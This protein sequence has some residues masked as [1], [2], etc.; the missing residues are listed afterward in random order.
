MKE[1]KITIGGDF[2]RIAVDA[3]EEWRKCGIISEKE[4]REIK[5]SPDSYDNMVKDGRIKS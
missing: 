5:E 4:Y 1:Y 2:N 3:I